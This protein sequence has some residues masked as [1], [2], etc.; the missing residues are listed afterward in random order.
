VRSRPPTDPL[1]LLPDVRDGLTRPERI[2]LHALHVLQ[3]E[4]GERSVPSARLYGLVSERL[5]LSPSEFEV[6]L[7]RL[8]GR[9][10]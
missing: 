7:A 10:G 2:V 6:L 5:C 8:V 3:Q 1:D 9:G 4:Y